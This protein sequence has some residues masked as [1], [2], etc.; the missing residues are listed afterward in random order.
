MSDPFDIDAPA[1]APIR[2]LVYDPAEYDGFRPEPWQAPAEV[3]EDPAS[4]QPAPVAGT[5]AEHQYFP[6]DNLPEELPSYGGEEYVHDDEL[7]W[8][9]SGVEAADYRDFRPGTRDIDVYWSWVSS[10]DVAA[11][12]Q[13][14]DYWRRV[15]SMLAGT[16]DLL[17][18]RRDALDGAWTGE[19]AAAFLERVGAARYSMDDWARAATNNAGMLDRVAQDVQLTKDTLGTLWSHYRSMQAHWQTWPRSPMVVYHPEH[20]DWQADFGRIIAP[21]ELQEPGAAQGRSDLYEVTSTDDIA[22][23]YHNHA[24]SAVELLTDTYVGN[25]FVIDQPREF[26]GSTSVSAH[27][28]P[29]AAPP[30]AAQSSYSMLLPASGSGEDPA[31]PHGGVDFG[32]LIARYAAGLAPPAGPGP[33]FATGGQLAGMVAAPPAAVPSAGLPPVAAPPGATPA[34]AG[35]APPGP[36]PPP[37]AAG[38]GSAGRPG[39]APLPGARPAG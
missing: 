27:G 34:L 1:A 37:G 26:Q 14:A 39:T 5:E 28:T 9:S 21:P 33:G 18:A 8:D 11:V 22:G 25:H 30:G 2:D 36:L 38:L 24:A 23:L 6:I 35:G 15:S 12:E 4:G 13:H 19:A 31:P 10:I 3:A 17:R 20:P 16:S 29:G 32:G 7:P